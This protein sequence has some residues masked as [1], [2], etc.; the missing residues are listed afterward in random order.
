MY[1]DPNSNGDE[2]SLNYK[3]AQKSIKAQNS[4][5]VLASEDPDLW[6]ASKEYV[7]EDL[8]AEIESHNILTVI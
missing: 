8:K 6:I 2:V 1:F 7:P 4:E 5:N 3:L